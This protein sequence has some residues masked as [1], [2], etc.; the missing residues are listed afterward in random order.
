MLELSIIWIVSYGSTSPPV[1][2]TPVNVSNQSPHTPPTPFDPAVGL[3][4][5]IMKI[6]LTVSL[7]GVM[8][9]SIAGLVVR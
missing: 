5:K 8:V 1:V 2:D 9:Y 7:T 3:V 6:G 4:D